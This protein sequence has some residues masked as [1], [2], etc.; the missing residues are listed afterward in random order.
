MQAALVLSVRFHD[1]RYHGTGAWPPAPARL[2]QALVAGAAQGSKLAAPYRAALGWLE[3]LEPP[4][5][6]APIARVGRSFTTYVP[7]NDLDSVGGD[8]ARLGEIRAAKAIRPRLF[9][10]ALPLT[11]A[12]T[13]QTNAAA[14]AHAQTT[15]TIAEHLFQLGRG[16]DMAWAE[17]RIIKAEA[18]D[19]QL[20][21]PGTTLF[22]PGIGEQGLPLVCPCSGSLQSLEQRF[23]GQR[24]QF[25]EQRVG[26]KM[27]TLFARPNKPLFRLISYNN[28][29]V[30][31]LFELRKPFGPGP[32]PDFAPVALTK[33]T[34]LV[35]SLRDGAAGRLRNALPGDPNHL[36][37]VERVFVG[38]HADDADKAARIRITPLPSIGHLHAN[39]AIRRILV[40]VPPDCPFSAGD[41]EWSFAGLDLTDHATG[42]VLAT[43]F[44]SD[45]RSML[46]HY[47][48]LPH[49]TRRVWRTV[50][51]AAL[52]EAAARRRIDPRRLT[53]TS[54][55]KGAGERQ[56][57]ETR[58]IEATW[59]A[60]RHSGI[61]TRPSRVQ[62]Q[63]EPFSGRGSRAEAFAPGT[64]FPKERLWH[65]EIAFPTPIQGPLAIGDGRY[66]GLGLMQPV[67]DGLLVFGMP[68][69]PRVAFDRRG[70]LLNAV[71]RALMACARRE[72]GG[73][74]RLFSG[75]EPDGSPAASGQHD[76]IFLAAAD[77]DRD[78]FLDRLL[79]VAPWMCD[80]S[81]RV[82]DETRILFNAV[83]SELRQVRAGA[84][85][86]LD[87][88]AP[89]TPD[90]A[91]ALVGPA[92]IWRS[93]TRYQLTRHPK[94][95]AGID[96]AVKADV[97][98]ECQRRQL[99]APTIEVGGLGYASPGELVVDLQLRFPKAVPGPILL[100]R[101][102]HRGGGLFLAVT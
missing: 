65:V 98:A 88:A 87:L 14:L 40:E 13:F 64:R 51:P 91:D 54:E 33:T 47:G 30:F 11:Y 39:Q 100:G 49:E 80:R 8:P 57:E 59:A 89:T 69:E 84:L 7:N 35:T 60:L 101:D 72:D 38:R 96:G 22:R 2:F 83:G 10:A 34:A 3:Q 70:D 37:A 76:H 74:P 9:N 97:L 75:H 42:E 46:R 50:T 29:S 41:I 23:A 85:G 81:I 93:H 27:R 63:R 78:G 26:R 28:P 15:C 82:T 16:V 86:V 90:D 71:R 62:V 52:P 21:A 56:I 94:R 53:E 17:A 19:A 4:I 92:R 48:M 99:P 6:A 79:V 12:W 66:L 43:L 61:D 25:S 24:R 45:Q 73:V 20:A 31:L 36:A 77:L 55:Q 44:A 68:A 18:I 95:R 5:I 1:G 102:S 58:A 67:D 32:L